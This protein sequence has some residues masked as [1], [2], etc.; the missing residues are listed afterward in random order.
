LGL[1]GAK[2]GDDLLCCIALQVERGFA[3]N[4][5][6]DAS[7]A[8]PRVIVIHHKPNLFSVDVPATDVVKA[9]HLA[10][11]PVRREVYQRGACG[12]S[13]VAADAA[14]SASGMS[15]GRLACTGAGFASKLVNHEKSGA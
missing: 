9:R 5:K 14:A 4:K 3:S 15:R 12:C 2:H 11:L 13:K 6:Y 10:I 7:V 1:L 8:F